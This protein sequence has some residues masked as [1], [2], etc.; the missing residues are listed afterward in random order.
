MKNIIRIIALLFLL[1]SIS[2]N[3]KQKA[4][5]SNAESIENQQNIT[6]DTINN[7][8]LALKDY[9]TTQWNEQKE[10]KINKI[11]YQDKVLNIY[12]DEGYI[13]SSYNFKDITIHKT[14]QT[15]SVEI[16]IYN[17]G[18]GSGGNVVITETYII[19]SVDSDNFQVKYANSDILK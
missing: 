3:T 14:R 5:S 13:L 9:L 18:G 1:N 17:E 6:K 16:T 4:E 8:V 2:C 7:Y 15:N 10:Q 11:T 12:G 19:T